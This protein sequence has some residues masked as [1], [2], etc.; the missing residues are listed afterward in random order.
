MIRRIYWSIF[1]RPVA[2]LV[3]IFIFFML[4]SSILIG[5]TMNVSALNQ[6]NEIRAK[7]GYKA[8]V[9]LDAKQLFEAKAK[10]LED[11]NY[12]API[13][14][15]DKTDASE[16]DFYLPRSVA[17]LTMKQA[18][19]LSELPV[20]KTAQYFSETTVISKGLKP[21]LPTID[22]YENNVEVAPGL[23]NPQFHLV[24]V[25]KS[26]VLPEF[27][28]MDYILVSGSDISNAD[29]QK[30][31]ALIN[32]TLAQN[33]NLKIG[34]SFELKSIDNDYSQTFKVSGIYVCTKKKN[35]LLSNRL[36]FLS[37]DNQIFTSVTAVSALKDGNF[38]EQTV[39]Q[40]TY[41]L[42]SPKDYED[43]KYGAIEKG[44]SQSIYDIYSDD[45]AYKNV[46][47]PVNKLFKTGKIILIVSILLTFFASVTVLH[48]NRKQ[49]GTEIKRLMA[50]GETN[51]RI[52]M[53]MLYEFVL[54]VSLAFLLVFLFSSPIL[55]ITKSLLNYLSN[56]I[57]GNPGETTYERT[58]E[59]FIDI[60]QNKSNGIG[61]ISYISTSFNLFNSA[62]MLVIGFFVCINAA[63]I[64]LWKLLSLQKNNL[65][66]DNNLEG[67]L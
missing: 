57:S 47:Q 22:V 23:S 58:G 65:L 26:E 61:F 52:F 16:K 30:N 3:C 67:L 24:G 35:T 7:W 20:V 54:L 5:L 62:G 44:I 64:P 51:T 53:H 63:L 27:Q 14:H 45:S 66:V 18:D 38:N 34:D 17:W 6:L 13:H 33:N 2:S 28:S 56:L 60:I 21:V 39:D 55:E 48:I 10:E 43:F 41:T 31:S 50:L 11:P 19:D 9:Q 46:S 49:R 40:A 8:V 4:G 59:Y 12:K 1:L 29:L 42:N 15:S 37:D 36:G 32:Q 25:L